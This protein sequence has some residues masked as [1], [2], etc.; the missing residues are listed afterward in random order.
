MDSVVAGLELD[1]AGLAAVRAATTRGWMACQEIAGVIRAA[2][3]GA[4]GHAGNGR[5]AAATGLG[6]GA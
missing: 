5:R 2:G 6:D 4:G 1:E 3:A